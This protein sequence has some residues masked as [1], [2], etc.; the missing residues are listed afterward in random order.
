MLDLVT[1]GLANDFLRSLIIC[2]LEMCSKD[3]C[4]GSE[5]SLGLRYFFSHSPFLRVPGSPF[6]G[7]FLR[8]LAQQAETHS[9]YPRYVSGFAAISARQA[10]QTSFA[11]GT[12]VAP[13]K[14]GSFKETGN[15]L[16]VRRCWIMDTD[17]IK[18]VTQKSQVLAAKPRNPQSDFATVLSEQEGNEKPASGTGPAL[19][20]NAS[21]SDQASGNPQRILMGTI[22][23]SMP[24]VSHLLVGHPE[25]G[26]EC[27]RIIHSEQNRQKPYTQ[28]QTGTAIFIDPETRKI[29]WGEPTR[30]PQP[31][32]SQVQERADQAPKLKKPETAD[33]ST[34]QHPIS[35]SVFAENDEITKK[36]QPVLLG[37]ITEST[38][39][40]SHLLFD[41]SRYRKN[42]WQIVH[43]EQNRDK[44]YKEIQ[45]G[46]AV[47][48]DPETQELSW[49]Q[50]SVSRE[51]V[52]S[53]GP[54][55]R[56]QKDG[57]DDA[58]DRDPFSR[59]LAKAVEPYIGRPYEELDCYELVVRGLVTMGV[60]YHGTGG[61]LERLKS[62]A[63]HEG[64]PGNAFLNGE[65]L[66]EASGTKVYSKS[67]V[68]IHD[69]Q[70]Q[71]SQVIGE[72]DA[73]LRRGYIVSFSTHTKGHTGIVSKN[74]GEWTFIN[75]GRMD[76]NLK[77]VTE[78]RL[79]GEEHLNEEIK[80]W[81]QLAASRK[82]S[83]KI[84]VGRLDEKKLVT[85]RDDPFP[86]AEE[87]KT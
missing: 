64:L 25:Y 59:Q 10:G 50:Q 69:A 20:K 28:I 71:A 47:Y 58:E 68:R 41:H 87:M 83:L 60:R 40:V 84:T 14:K 57:R 8:P 3:A 65:G 46:T 62:M 27:W 85:F 78:L 37:T 54:A 19:P 9:D 34:K 24:T 26:E 80:D 61:L 7:G 52:A 5:D 35:E 38:P 23:E 56:R 67:F 70:K 53:E 79:V 82:E 39:T 66:V 22:T 74:N 13:S 48:L 4:S 43:S 44:P 45:Q 12:D 29:D 1:T 72:L 63:V 51:V 32:A 2:P 86:G 42:T 11:R 73:L 31:I 55:P 77:T 15:N 16:F 36:H 33:V 21:D 76:N 17:A 49:G 75:S 81:F 6:G 18:G 30:E